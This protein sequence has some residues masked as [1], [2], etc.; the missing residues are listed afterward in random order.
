MFGQSQIK[1][2]ILCVFSFVYS[3]AFAIERDNITCGIEMGYPLTNGYGPWDY[4][5]PEHQDKLPIVI[6]VHFDRNVATLRKGMT[7][8]LPHADIDYTLRAIPNYHPA[9]FSVSKLE[10][11][12][13]KK[14]SPGE[15]YRP[16]FYSASC[17]LKRAIYFQPKDATAR[18]LY[19][20][21]LHQNK[22]YTSAETEYIAASNIQPNNPEIHYN[23]GLLYIDM[24]MLKEAQTQAKIA[25]DS[26]YPLQGLRNK[27]A[28][29]KQQQL[30]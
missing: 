16:K 13:R 3:S 21:Y 11:S 12:D 30:R 19:A 1:I 18:M 6:S 14:L 10:Q 24:K 5:N 25:Y 7:S 29:F 15:I 22:Q 20:I 23:L 4:T 17:Y 28:R 26:G 27:I 9:L 2:L 8:R